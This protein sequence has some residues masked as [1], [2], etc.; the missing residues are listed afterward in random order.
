MSTNTADVKRATDS[1]ARR[2]TRSP[3]GEPAGAAVAKAPIDENG[4]PVIHR[5]QIA[6]RNLKIGMFVAEL[7]RPWLDTPFLIQG[8]LLDAESELQSLQS[9]CK[10]VFVDLDMSD[11]SVVDAI[12]SAEMKKLPIH[13]ER[14][15]REPF[16]FSTKTGTGTTKP[17]KDRRIS[18]DGRVRFKNYLRLVDP[19]AGYKDTSLL[20]RI[21]S[22]LDRLFSK[23]ENRGKL[24]SEAKDR[25][26]ELRKTLP[27]DI[28]LRRYQ[29][30][31]SVEQELPRARTA[32]DKSEATLRTLAS[33]VKSGRLPSLE[34]ASEVVDDIVQSMIDNPDAMMWVARMRD[35]DITTYGHAVKVALYMVALGR[36]MGFPKRELSNLGMIGLLA[37]IGKTKLPKALLEKP[38]MLSPQEYTLVKEHVRLGLESLSKDGP[39]PPDILQGIAQHHE[40][41]DG[42]GYPKGLKGPEIG[43]YGR[44]AAI[45]DTFSALI[46]PRVYANPV[47]PHDALL[48]LFEWAGS[49]FHEPL[50]EQFVQAVGVFPVGSMVELSTK[51]IAIV[52][53]HN[54]VR[55]LEPRVLVLTWIDKTPLETPIERNLFEKPKGADGKPIR[56][57]R[58]VPAGSHGLK[59]KDYYGADAMARANGLL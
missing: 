9:H 39:L 41:L 13:E 50:V 21:S 14:P 51:E 10:F 34:Q 1:A 40:R 19:K 28:K 8:F 33:D 57:M 49:S 2:Q 55:R 54:K 16:K 6:T 59:I 11:P 24:L 31:S 18:N 25:L 3:N 23:K 12:R 44:M 35:E 53:A 26:G 15:R 32:F 5:Y 37:D 22:L 38:G 4:Q 47:S 30:K 45:A 36:H 52:L 58:A 29:D 48:N 7:D 42:S 43:I 56:I 20:G 27:P 17:I 46:T